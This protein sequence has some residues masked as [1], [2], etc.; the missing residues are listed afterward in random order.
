MT[1]NIDRL[2]DRGFISFSDRGDLMIAPA[3]GKDSLRRLGLPVDSPLNV[4]SF[5]ANQQKEMC[6][7]FIGATYSS[8]RA[9]MG[10]KA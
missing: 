10:R 8:K 7:S 1:P 6:C 2:F 3:A 4:G 9:S 5:S